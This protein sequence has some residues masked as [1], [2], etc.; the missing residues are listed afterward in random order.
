MFYI[1]ILHNI[2]ECNYT[3]VSTSIIR[4][5]LSSLDLPRN[6]FLLH[7]IMLILV[8]QYVQTHDTPKLLVPFCTA[9]ISKPVFV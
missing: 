7:S 3:Q 2:L 6:I 9:K 4:R 1:C 8:F 5:N